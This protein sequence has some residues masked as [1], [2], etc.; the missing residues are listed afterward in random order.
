MPM[1]FAR[2]G[3]PE[4]RGSGKMSKL[5]KS[6]ARN[7]GHGVAP[8]IALVIALVLAVHLFAGQA[9]AQLGGG[10]QAQQGAQAT[11][12]PLSGRG[13][14]GGGVNATQTP[15]PGTTA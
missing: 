11:P 10:A 14:A 3:D 15:I 9:F 12:L 13:G 2:G 4:R 1:T 5:R 8:V 6:A 7:G